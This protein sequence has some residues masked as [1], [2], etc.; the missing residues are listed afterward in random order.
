MK[1]GHG[2]RCAYY[3]DVVRP[4]ILNTPPV[5]DTR[6]TTCEIHLLTCEADWLN[7][8][9]ALKSFYWASGRAYALCIHDDGSLS[10]TARTEIQAQFPNGRLVLRDEA[11]RLAVKRLADYPMTRQFR[12]VHRA[13]PKLID[14][15]AFL[16]ADRMLVLDSDILF[17]KPPL[18]ILEHIHSPSY[19]KNCFNEDISTS[20]TITIDEAREAFHVD[21]LE[22]INCGF[23]LVQNNSL[24]Y[25]WIEEFLNVDG[26]ADKIDVWVTEQT[27]YALCS[28][29][30]GAELL[31]EDYTLYFEKGLGD[32]P[33][34]HYVGR[35]RH[36]MYSEGIR[37]LVRAGMLN[38]TG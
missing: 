17:F 5:T 20:Y 14:F 18:A 34:R 9:W 7:A 1:Y 24:R 21:L 37:A 13:A 6:D 35:I 33:F 26:M 16:D 2:L 25:D 4:K 31:P 23:G 15:P 36:L 11:D 10:E 3:R 27:L 28:S 12:Q 32:R 22:R 38:H 8:I 19:N 30:H 29:R